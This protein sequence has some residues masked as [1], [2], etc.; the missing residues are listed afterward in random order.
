MLAHDPA[1]EHT[2]MIPVSQAR[3][4][5]AIAAPAASTNHVSPMEIFVAQPI[6]PWPG[7]K[8]RLAKHLL[9]LFDIPHT[10]YVEAF[11]GAAAMLFARP[12][13]AKVEVLNDVNRDLVNLYRVVAHHLDEFVRQFRWALSSREM[14]R[15]AQLQHVDTL[16]DVQRA[17]RFFY[18]QRL[19]FGGKVVGQSFGVDTHG[20]NAINLLRVEEDLSA[21][22]LR[23][24]QVVIEH[25]AWQD[26][27]GRYDREHTLFFLD[28]PYWQTAGYGMP[29]GLEQ[30]EQL[31]VRMAAL[32]GRAVLTI[33]DHPDMRRIFAAFRR[34]RVP[35]SYTIGGA[36]RAKQT[37]ELIFTTW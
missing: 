15:W 36:Q 3:L 1:L 13:P 29:F 34:R 2:G 11:A 17:A 32:Q 33:N 12:E 18:L 21:A 6:I 8:R 4:P 7:G 28:P 27:L 5:A 22:H 30:Y 26:C 37:A 14:F 19:A 31:A 25:L 20:R 16:T 23:L 24:N 9:P 10:C 35:I